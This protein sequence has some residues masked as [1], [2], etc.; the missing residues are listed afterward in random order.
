LYYPDERG[1]IEAFAETTLQI[2][3]RSPKYPTETIK[4][5]LQNMRIQSTVPYLGS[6]GTLQVLEVI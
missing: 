2:R 1:K 3:I 6:P 4:A 5:K